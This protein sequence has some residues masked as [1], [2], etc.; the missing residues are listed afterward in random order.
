MKKIITSLLTLLSFSC[1]V[2]TGCQKKNN[3]VW[4]DNQTAGKLKSE[5]ARK[6]WGSDDEDHLS[7]EQEGTLGPAN[8][9]YIALNEEDL[10]SQISDGAIPQPEFS[11]GEEGSGLPGIDQFRIPSASLASIFS[12]VYFNT[13][14]HI[15]RGK[16]YLLVLDNIAS[17][18]KNHPQTY[19]FVEGHCDE[20][21]PEA[22]NL[23]LGARRA[24]YIRTMLIK[25]GVDV[26]QI[27]TVSY[28]K[29]KPALNDHTPE[30]WA[31]NRRAEFKVFQKS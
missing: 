7:L 28:G 22:Y 24:N 30:A 21:G 8:E 10:K 18:L 13:D 14:D 26:N 27:H 16:D 15:L 17:Y 23:S 3:G 31:K 12:T 5:K 11:P 6:L 25:K 20:R 19:I 29:E 9:E 2:F 1:L 4:D